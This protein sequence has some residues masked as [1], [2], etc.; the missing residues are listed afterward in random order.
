MIEATNI[1]RDKYYS[2]IINNGKERIFKSIYAGSYDYDPIFFND[3]SFLI[4]SGIKDSQGQTLKKS[5]NKLKTLV[6]FNTK[7][8]ST[9]L[10]S[11]LNC[12]N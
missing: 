1:G 5:S 6:V 11:V 12:I 2:I 8:N 4:V 9:E 7:V 3:T 10:F